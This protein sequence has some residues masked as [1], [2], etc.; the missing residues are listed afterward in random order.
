MTH[1]LRSMTNKYELE[2]LTGHFNTLAAQFGFIP[3]APTQLLS[4]DE[5]LLFANSTIA[6]YKRHLLEGRVPFPGF[7]IVQECIRN[8]N[9]KSIRNWSEELEYMSCFTQLG[10]LG[11]PNSLPRILEFITDYLASISSRQRL[12]CRVSRSLTLYESVTCKCEGWRIEIDGR[13]PGYYHWKY[14]LDGVSGEGVTFAI[15]DQSRGL[16]RDIGNLVEIR[17]S[18]GVLGYEFGFG[19]ETL[20]SRLRGLDSPFESSPLHDYLDVGNEP[21][22]KRKMLDSLMLAA[23]LCAIGVDETTLKRA[24]ILRRAM[25]DLF[26]LTYLCRLEPHLVLAA[27]RQ[28]LQAKGVADSH[29][30]RSFDTFQRRVGSKIDLARQYIDYARMHDKA[31]GHV[32]RYCVD[33]MGIPTAYFERIFEPPQAH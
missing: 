8:Q 21:S 11:G 23:M 13:P 10:V 17:D 19:G 28:Y 3:A 9:L 31:W 12:L 26:Y 1:P 20:D 25:N 14:G 4:D 16:Y 27:G 22:L 33:R 2:A 24:S 5:T 7:S 6:G 30:V 18:A 32:R 29:F 15:Q